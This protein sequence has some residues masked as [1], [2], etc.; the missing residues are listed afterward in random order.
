M[1]DGF[2]EFSLVT[3]VQSFNKQFQKKKKKK[4]SLVQNKFILM[5]LSTTEF[6]NKIK[7]QINTNLLSNNRNTL[8]L[9]L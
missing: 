8:C 3:S 5:R 6:K 1:K 9:T 2:A 4:G 7:E